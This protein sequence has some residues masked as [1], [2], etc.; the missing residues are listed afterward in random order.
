MRCACYANR[1]PCRYGD[2]FWIRLDCLTLA[3]L[4]PRKD[5]TGDFS[6][7]RPW[8]AFSL[9][10]AP[11]WP[12]RTRRRMLQRRHPG[13]VQ[14]PDPGSMPLAEPLSM[15]YIKSAILRAL[16]IFPDVGRALS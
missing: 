4:V 2:F 11:A 12:P 9:S 15:R 7:F 8:R 13:Q 1:M 10:Q 16:F 3:A 6:V 14:A 5:G